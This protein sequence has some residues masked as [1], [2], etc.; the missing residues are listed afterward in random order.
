MRVHSNSPYCVH[1][2]LLFR[3]CTDLVVSTARLEVHVDSRRYG[4]WRELDDSL[5][6]WLL[7]W[8][9]KD[10]VEKDGHSCPSIQHRLH[11]LFSLFWSFDR[12]LLRG[13]RRYNSCNEVQG[14]D[15][16]REPSYALIFFL[17]FA[18]FLFP[19]FV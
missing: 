7:R 9:R 16:T 3:D 5:E 2:H 4:L 14:F 13:R 17:V 10:T 18:L 6:N 8:V 19:N 12:R 1:T 11:F 15:V